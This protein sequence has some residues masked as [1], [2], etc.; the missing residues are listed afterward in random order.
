VPLLPNVGDD[1]HINFRKLDRLIPGRNKNMD[2]ICDRIIDGKD[3]IMPEDLVVLN[4]IEDKEQIRK[5]S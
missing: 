2:F 3:F 4:H 5:A 1:L